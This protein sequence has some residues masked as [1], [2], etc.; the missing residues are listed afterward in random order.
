MKKILVVED[1][2]SL[3]LLYKEE[4]SEEGYKVT[5][6]LN[7]EAALEALSKEHFDLIVTDIRMPGKNGI[8]LASQIMSQQSDVPVIINTAYQSYRN[9]FKTWAADAYV[10]K[11]S[12]LDELKAKIKEL[13]EKHDVATQKRPD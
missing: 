5:T 4:L 10:V 1:E 7:A 13:L 3:C 11:S 8:E 12:S 2:K 6:A 9:D